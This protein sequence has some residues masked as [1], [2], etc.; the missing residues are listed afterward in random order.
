M[1]GEPVTE[2]FS[3][4]LSKS[5]SSSL[6]EDDDISVRRAGELFGLV[7]LLGSRELFWPCRA[8]KQIKKALIFLNGK[9]DKIPTLL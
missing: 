1:S 4:S 6:I 8:P 3:L 7:V 5:G 2:I 9:I